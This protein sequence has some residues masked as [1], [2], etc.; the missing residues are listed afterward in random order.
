MIV[1]EINTT[2]NKQKIHSK[3]TIK[4]NETLKMGKAN[5]VSRL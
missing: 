4:K 3:K 2:N 1:Q 5:Y